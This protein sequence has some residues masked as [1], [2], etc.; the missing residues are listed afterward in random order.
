MLDQSL[1]NYCD[2]DWFYERY[3]PFSPQGRRLRDERVFFTDASQLAFEHRLIDLFLVMLKEADQNPVVDKIKGALSRL[4]S[5]EA[6]I[7][8]GALEADDIFVVKRFLFNARVVLG[9]LAPRLAELFG[10][11]A[12]P[13]E[14]LA[15]LGQTEAEGESFFVADGRDPRLGVLRRELARLADDLKKKR[16]ERLAEI[17]QVAKIAF[18]ERE[19]VIV[20]AQRLAELTALAT[21]VSVEN[22]D[23]M[24]IMVRPRPSLDEIRLEREMWEKRAAERVVEQEVCAALGA[25]IVAAAPVIQELER[26]MGRLDAALAKA[27]LAREFSLV[28]PLIGERLTLRAG[29]Y[30]PLELACREAGRD[31]VPLD[32]DL[33]A[34][35]ALVYG[36][37]MGG[38]S[39][40]LRTI[41]FLQV[42]TQLGFYVPAEALVTRLYGSL[43]FVGGRATHGEDGISG[44]GAELL[45]FQQ[46]W[47]ARS[48]PSLFLIDEF[49]ATTNAREAIALSHALMETMCEHPGVCFLFATHFVEDG[50]LPAAIKILRMQ[51]MD[52]ARFAAFGATSPDASHTSKVQLLNQCMTYKIVEQ[53]EVR[54]VREAL[55]VA[56][57]LGLDAKMLERAERRMEDRDE[58]RQA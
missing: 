40:V 35:S 30:L 58:P 31:Y 45:A 50:P 36:S 37:N 43:S 9:A 7:A 4:T 26:I 1:W 41:G 47:Q 12:F 25:R 23:G 14:L 15:A 46:R 24:H 20:G 44:F 10:P 11:I 17:S 56:A 22:H 39:V 27:L 42:M 3:R 2:C 28:R 49:A 21:L 29:R 19:F 53:G 32:M 48:T 33:A 6:S 18:G 55:R 38:K 13:D 51:G 5:P 16:S 54:M 34:L 57:F 52:R 8:A